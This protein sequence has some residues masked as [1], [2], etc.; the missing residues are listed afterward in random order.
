MDEQKLRTFNA[1]ASFV[2]DL[3]TGFGKRYRPVALYNRLV[4]HTTFKNIEAINK[5]IKAFKKF[6][7][8]NPTYI[9]DQVVGTNSCITY[10]ERI[11]LN[12][13]KILSKTDSKT[14]KH[15]YEHLVTIYSLI[16]LGTDEGKEALENLKTQNE[17]DSEL[18]L[19]FPDT[20]EG[21]FVKETLNEMT[22]QFE[23]MDMS[24]S[25]NPMDMVSNMMQSGFFSKF[26]GDLQNKFES[27]DMDIKSL[28]GTVTGVISE[29][30]PEDG[31][32]LDQLRGFMGQV[33][34]MAGMAGM[35]EAPE[36]VQSYMDDILNASSAKK[37]EPQPKIEEL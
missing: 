10:S 26:M 6:F 24:E 33:G 15:I 22:A 23:D 17:Q 21:N 4:G 34:G 8:D 7:R 20:N 27:G 9:K 28:M 1:I 19:N 5:H 32:E 2:Q 30:T 36:E 16:N 37:D 3:D 14:H 12:V 29:S 35:G 18:E 31:P 25:A 13:G 11:F